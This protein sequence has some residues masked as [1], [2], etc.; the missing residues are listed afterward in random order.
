ME[1]AEDPNA[2]PRARVDRD[3]SG[4]AK[5]NQL[6]GPDDTRVYRSRDLSF[7]ICVHTCFHRKLRHKY[8][9]FKGISEPDILH[10]GLKVD[11]TVL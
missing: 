5:L 10:K 1:Q 11:E 4:D 3:L 2:A 6:A 7:T 8:H 9:A